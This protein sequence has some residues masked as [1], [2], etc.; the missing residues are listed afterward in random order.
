MNTAVKVK[1]PKSHWKSFWQNLIFLAKLF[2]EKPLETFLW[3]LRAC[4]RYLKSLQSLYLYASKKIMT[5][6]WGFLLRHRV[7]FKAPALLRILVRIF[8]EK[9]WGKKICPNLFL[10]FFVL[11]NGTFRHKYSVIFIIP[12]V[13]KCFK[14][15]KVKIFWINWRSKFNINSNSQTSSHWPC[16]SYS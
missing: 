7:P 2:F 9:Y 15:I 11:L 16:R 5:V 13:F 3:T 12:R 14:L 1:Y 8:D 6:R 10:Y 4:S